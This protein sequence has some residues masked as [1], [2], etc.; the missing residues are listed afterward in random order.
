MSPTPSRPEPADH[1]TQRDEDAQYYRQVLH[2]LVE[3][4]TR[5]A[6]AIDRQ[7]AAE[8]AATPA[9]APEQPGQPAP[10]PAPDPTPD[11]TIAFDRIARTIRRTIALARKLSDPA[12]PSPTERAAADAQQ[13]RR[14]ARKQIIRE[15]EDT[16]HRDVHGPDAEA[17]AESL[18]AELYERLDTLDLDDD[19]DT[20]PIADIVAAIRRDL[21]I[22]AHINSRGISPWKRRTPR[23]V[24]DL[25]ARAAGPGIAQPRTAQPRPA[26]PGTGHPR[27]LPAPPPRSRPG[28]GPPAP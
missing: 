28:T 16:I 14:A 9:P 24:R 8:P 12:Q 27:P 11:L 21:G 6:R 18:H 20:L 2:E 15:V 10:A 5:L 7:A 4:G 26:Q 23:D 3:I 1:A 13:R 22:A 25:C 19:I 17:R